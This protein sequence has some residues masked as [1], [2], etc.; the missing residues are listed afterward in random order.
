MLLLKQKPMLN[1]RIAK[2][3]S[4]FYQDLEEYTD[5]ES[6]M[7]KRLAEITATTT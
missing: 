4:P 5:Y 1:K 2:G 7:N 3:Q 6:A